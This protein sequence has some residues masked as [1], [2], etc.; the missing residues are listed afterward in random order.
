MSA[1]VI[2]RKLARAIGQ[3]K[4][5]GISSRGRALS[6]HHLR[7]R[8]GLN[9]FLPMQISRY[10]KKNRKS[11]TVLTMKHAELM[12]LADP[13]VNL[14]FAVL[15]AGVIDAK[16]F[17]RAGLYDKDGACK[18]WPTVLAKGKKSKSPR[19]IMSSKDLSLHVA[20]KHFFLGGEYKQ[21]ADAVGFNEE[22]ETVWQNILSVVGEEPEAEWVAPRPRISRK[23]RI[24]GSFNISK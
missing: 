12:P 11:S 16:G 22:P 13:V 21:W 3:G 8:C 1:T 24:R 6:P 17:A 14:A 4:A 9:H 10:R 5:G 7:H 15:A 20:T 2:R 18:P 23:D 19:N